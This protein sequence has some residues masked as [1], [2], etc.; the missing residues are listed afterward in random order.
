MIRFD[1]GHVL[2]VKAPCALA[3]SAIGLLVGDRGDRRNGGN[4]RADAFLVPERILTL[5]LRTGDGAANVERSAVFPLLIAGALDDE[6]NDIW[7]VDES[8]V[9]FQ[10]RLFSEN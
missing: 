6:L 9:E 2:H 4:K 1:N 10:Y 3:L 8:F 7:I 5:I